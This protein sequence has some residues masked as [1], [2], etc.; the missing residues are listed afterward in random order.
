MTYL[1]NQ[2]LLK[3]FEGRY[4]DD[5]DAQQLLLILKATMQREA[6]LR[7]FVA[8]VRDATEISKTAGNDYRKP[9]EISL[10]NWSKTLLQPSE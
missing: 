9:W 5:L 1:M 2:E 8:C 10:N 7:E 3:S 6:A 4:L